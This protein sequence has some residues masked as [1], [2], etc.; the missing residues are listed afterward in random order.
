[1]T[2]QQS[3]ADIPYND[4]ANNFDDD[5]DGLA[6]ALALVEAGTGSAALAL[7]TPTTTPT[8]SSHLMVH[9]MEHERVSPILSPLSASSVSSASDW[10]EM[11][12]WT[13]HDD[14]LER[15]AL[16]NGPILTTANPSSSSS[17]ASSA[18]FQAHQQLFSSLFLEAE[19]D[20]LTHKSVPLSLSMA[21]ETLEDTEFAATSVASSRAKH[22]LEDVDEFATPASKRTRTK[23]C[24]GNIAAA[25]A[26]TATSPVPIAPAPT[27]SSSRR[28][29][30]SS[31]T[32]TGGANFPVLDKEAKRKL[33]N[34]NAARKSREKKLQQS[35]DL[36]EQLEK[37]LAA[38]DSY[39]KRVEQLEQSNHALQQE[40]DALMAALRSRALLAGSA[41]QPL[42][43]A[44]AAQPSV[45]AA[46]LAEAA[47]PLDEL[48]FADI[49]ST[50]WDSAATQQCHGDDQQSSSQL[51]NSLTSQQQQ[52]HQQCQS[53]S[54][55]QPQSLLD[56]AVRQSSNTCSSRAARDEET[57]NESAALVRQPM[58]RGSLQSL[59]LVM[60]TSM[61]A[62]LDQTPL[63]RQHDPAL[64]QKEE[65]PPK[66]HDRQQQQQL[67]P[68]YQCDKLQYDQT[69]QP[70]LT[71]V[72]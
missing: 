29:P 61:L 26:A 43:T 38:R 5:D 19:A 70:T 28:H 39:S 58:Q 20:M 16:M 33:S 3:A 53:Q 22:I 42:P 40:R 15:L 57:F 67:A 6:R 8:T 25:A 24:N 10:L 62:M 13:G 55:Q 65:N 54:Q 59:V 64:L 49:F 1:M 36:N 52:Q 7:T 18:S 9:M 60:L 12:D 47:A 69:W 63:P 50:T 41:D 34:R 17:S 37:A 68:Q 4:S 71:V 66:Q 35:A 21:L 48:S 45:Q 46:A 30:A 11:Q 51:D 44:A 32:S 72:C 2:L 23:S 31:A 27:S 56:R 14:E